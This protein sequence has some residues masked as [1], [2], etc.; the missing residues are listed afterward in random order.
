MKLVRIVPLAFLVILGAGCKKAEKTPGEKIVE[1]V[2]AMSDAICKCAE[3]DGACVE[4]ATAGDDD[5]EARMKAEF[6]KNK[7]SDALQKRV[8]AAQAKAGKCAMGEAPPEGSGTG[9]AAA[10]GPDAEATKILDDMYAL[11]DE[12]CKCTDMT[13]ADPLGKKLDE[14]ETK[15]T[16]L[17]P[18]ISK[19]PADLLKRGEDLETQLKDCMAKLGGDDPGAK[20]PEAIVDEAMGMFKAVV[21]EVCACKDMACAEAAMEKGEAGEKKLLEAYSDMSQ[22]PADAKTKMDELEKTAKGCIEKLGG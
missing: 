16:S 14:Q 22:V 12:I 8:D 4:K 17:Y 21:D 15:L 2:E 7:P 1:E 5:L 13:C 3:G 11:K 6:E 20:S 9:T 19:V 10:T 18:D